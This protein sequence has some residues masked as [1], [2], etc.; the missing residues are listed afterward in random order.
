V[1]DGG[2]HAPPPDERGLPPTRRGPRREPSGT[3]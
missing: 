3:M 1:E 2:R